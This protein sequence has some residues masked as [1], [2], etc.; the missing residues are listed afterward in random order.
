MCDEQTRCYA[1]GV[2]VF[3]VVLHD[4]P[5]DA[6]CSSSGLIGK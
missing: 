6:R 4:T 5:V 3:I 1:C 2:A